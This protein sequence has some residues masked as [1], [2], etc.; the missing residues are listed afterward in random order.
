M[1]SFAVAALAVL[2]S[3][4]L[5]AQS[6]AP[7]QAPLGSAIV[8]NEVF[9]GDLTEMKK[10]RLIRAGVAYNRTHYFIDQGVQRGMAYEMLKLW[11]DQ[12][13]AGTKS[14][15][16][17]V[18][19]MFVPMSR[20][21]MAPALLEGHVD[22]IAA[23]VTVTPERRR[24]AAFSDPV[25]SDVNEIVV[26][27]PGAAPIATKADLGGKAVLV[28]K[29]S[30]YHDN[31]LSLNTRLKAQG[32]P[33][34]MIQLAPMALEDDDVLEMVNA[35]ISKYTVVDNFLA[36]FWQQI[37]T[38]LKLHPNIALTLN[39]EIAVAMRPNNPELK[40]A[41]NAFLKK[42]GSGSMIG[43]MLT[44]RYLSDTKFAKN[45]TS[46]AEMKR[47]QQM[48][49][50]FQKYSEQYNVDFLLMAAQGYQE[51]GLDQSVRS[52]VGAIGVMQVMPATGRELAVGDIRKM[53]TNIHAGVKYV[54]F[55]MDQYYKDEP[56][57]DLNKALMTFAGYNAGP[58]RIRTLRAET[59]KRGLNPNLWFNNVERVVADRI[60][61]ETVTYVS[62]IYK[63]YVAY[64]LAREQVGERKQ[65]NPSVR[66]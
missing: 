9:K 18:H 59:A 7:E 35:G 30:S 25:R 42:N 3:A 64:T 65:A 2:L 37:F 4:M 27:G 24:L 8:Q 1:K 5:W 32:R 31:L 60:G 21:E 39:G 20:D 15:T 6:P 22:L 23:N 10:R 58:N 54:R 26:S 43:N 51:S 19:V 53:E 36:E 66:K 38:G 33:E 47:F 46:E 63:Y 40:A 12:M 16:D 13:N 44:K 56:M 57:D 34:V 28:R 29:N 50:F 11:E 49:G 41:V 17:K 61:R 14:L 52:R 48:V 62:N 45:A 55:M